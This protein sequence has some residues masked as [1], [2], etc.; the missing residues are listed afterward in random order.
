MISPR[1]KKHVSDILYLQKAKPCMRKVLIDKA[2][3]SLVECLCEIADNVLRGNVHLTPQQKDKLKR[4]RIGL[5]QLTK[6][7]VPLKT[8]KVILQKGG[9]L[10][11]LLAPIASVVAPFIS[12]LLQ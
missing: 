5:R 2:D 10:G 3:R 8:K 4:N 7:S 1:L 9:F 11:S 12:T 6:K